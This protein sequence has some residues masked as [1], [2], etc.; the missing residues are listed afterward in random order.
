[1]ATTQRRST[2]DTAAIERLHESFA[3]QR[4]AFLADS[5]PALEARLERVGAVAEMVLANRLRIRDALSAD[6]GSHPPLFADMV[7]T[8]GMAGR[9]AFVAENLP[10][11]LEPERRTADPA[12]YGTGWAEMRHEPKGVIGNIVPWNFPFD[13]SLGPLIDMLAAGNRVIIKPS[14]F[15][16]ECADL[17]A[18][19]IAATFPA[20]LVDVAVGGLDL[21]QEFASVRWDHLLYTGSPRVGREVAKAAA[22]NLVPT[23]L[24]LG[25]KTPAILLDDAVEP[26]TVEHI[27]GIKMIK[28]GQMCNTVDHVLVPADQVDRFVELAEEW[29]AGAV[30]DY[31]RTEDCPGIISDAHLDRVL[32][33]IEEARDAGCRVIQLDKEGGVDRETRRV[34]MHLVVDPPAG[35]GLA[36]EEVFGPI[37]PVHSY[38]SLDAAIEKV[39]EGQRPLGLYVFTADDAAGDDILARTSSGGACVNAC[40]LQGALPSLGFGGVGQSGT[41]RH[42]GIDGFREFTNPRGVFHRGTDDLCALFYPPFDERQQGLVDGALEG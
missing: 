28:N 9:A 8:L 30:P 1:M 42:H 13:L 22:E 34:P 33:L 37:L 2:D 36:E 41:G 11:W 26:G 25:G 29:V 19:M 5:S 15:A 27:V 17:L 32:G 18:S 7:E 31:S 4:R 3:A 6:F 21:A 24:E 35:T 39:N 23:T 38:A 14:E 40:A 10:A 16:P 20:D 12:M